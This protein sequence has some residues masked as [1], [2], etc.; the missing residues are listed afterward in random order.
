MFRLEWAV[1]CQSFAV[2]RTTN[3][4]SIFNV[5]EDVATPPID[6]EDKNPVLGPAVSVVSVWIAD[7]AEP[8]QAVRVT[9]IAPDKKKIGSAIV[10]LEP[11]SA[12][13][14]R[15]I[16]TF[17]GIPYRGPGTYAFLIENR[18]DDRWTKAKTLTISI[19]ERAA[20]VSVATN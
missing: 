7:A 15:A 10:E 16:V 4:V 1:V 20:P 18:K 8:I 17:G 13:R 6:P 14:Y 2:D 19:S 3:A 12:R 9:L 5:V 11:K